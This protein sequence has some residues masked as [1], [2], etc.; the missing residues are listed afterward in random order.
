MMME[1]DH[2]LIGAYA[3]SNTTLPSRSEY[4]SIID[5]LEI[6]S[7]SPSLQYTSRNQFTDKGSLF[8]RCLYKHASMHERLVFGFV[9]ILMI[10]ALCLIGYD[11]QY[12]PSI[13]NSNTVNLPKMNK[14][15]YL[16]RHDSINLNQIENLIKLLDQ[17]WKHHNLSDVSSIIAYGTIFKYVQNFGHRFGIF[18]FIY[19]SKELDSM[20]PLQRSINV[21]PVIATELTIDVY[22]I[23]ENWMGDT[24]LYS[25]ERMYDIMHNF[26]TASIILVVMS[27]DYLIGLLNQMKLTVPIPLNFNQT[28]TLWHINLEGQLKSI[29]D[30]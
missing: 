28:Y 14:H 1:N 8:R 20:R 2:L 18:D 21:L 25:S 16:I 6:E 26:P 27:S 17:E 13:I 15:I 29:G 9:V 24:Q 22:A 30:Y 11:A 4:G 3:H 12:E 5:P 10:S 23:E 19:E 7:Q